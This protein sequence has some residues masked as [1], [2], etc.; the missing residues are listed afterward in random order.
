MSEAGI[1]Y[2]VCLVC[3]LVGLFVGF[4]IGRTWK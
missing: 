4:R 1:A 2:L 3:T